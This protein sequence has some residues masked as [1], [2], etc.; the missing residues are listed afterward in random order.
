MNQFKF[1][2]PVPSKHRPTDFHQPFRVAPVRAI[3]GDETLTL[4][5]KHKGITSANYIVLMAGLVN[6][7]FYNRSVAQEELKGWVPKQITQLLDKEGITILV[8]LERKTTFEVKTH[9]RPI[10]SLSEEFDFRD[11]GQGIALKFERKF[12]PSM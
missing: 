2:I 3:H 5:V 7:L 10:R 12:L 6:A 8:L 1:E 9:V 4:S 11:V